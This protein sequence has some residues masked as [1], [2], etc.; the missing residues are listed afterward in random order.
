MSKL[1][2]PLDD[3]FEA[4]E[5]AV[6]KWRTK[7]SKEYIEKSVT[8]LLD[9]NKETIILKILGFT[10]KWGKWE[11][12]H[13]NSRAGNG[14]MTDLI[15]QT[16]S[17]KIYKWIETITM[18]KMTAAT[19]KALVAEYNVM[20]K[21]LVNRRM[22]EAASVHADEMVEKLMKQITDDTAIEADKR[23]AKLLLHED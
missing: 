15:E 4:F 9:Q 12:D 11:V 17:D 20:F 23:M 21:Q 22:K 14:T 2:L 13:C 18:P 19:K 1:V 3:M 16:W 8:V 6:D 10:N 5:S 7:H